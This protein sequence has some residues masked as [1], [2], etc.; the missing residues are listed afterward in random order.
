MTVND[1]VVVL[2]TFTYQ[3]GGGACSD[4]LSVLSIVGDVMAKYPGTTAEGL[5]LFFKAVEQ[6]LQA[7]GEDRVCGYLA[8]DVEGGRRRRRGP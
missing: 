4:A 1:R 3:H 8:V 6:G 7:D 5:A 2:P